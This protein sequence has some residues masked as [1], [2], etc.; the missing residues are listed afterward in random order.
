MEERKATD[1]V[2]ID[3][4][5]KTDIAYYMI[6]ASGTS[7]RHISAIAERIIIEL[8]KKHKIR[9]KTEGLVSET[10]WV[11]LDLGGIIIHLFQP[12]TRELY[13]IEDL[14]QKT[15]PKQ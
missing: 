3:L 9:P 4:T 7:A 2:N 6:I 5:E 13:K 12:E 11:L 10:R 15:P 1:I 14:W 8:K